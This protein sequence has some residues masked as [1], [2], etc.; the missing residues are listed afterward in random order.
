VLARATARRAARSGAL[1]GAVF[2]LTVVS[3]AL[4]YS[5]TF[6]TAASRAKLAASLGTNAG[7][8]ALLGTARRIDTVAGFTA[9][10]CLG[11]LTLIGA[12]WGLLTA[13]RLLRGEE[14][15]GRWEL[16]LS[17]QTTRRGAASQAVAGL[18]AGLLALW[19]VTAGLTVAAGST[20]EAGFSITASLFL[21]TALVMGAAVFLAVGAVVSQLAGTR[22]QANGIAAGVLGAS[23]LLRMVADSSSQPRGLGGVPRNQIL[24]WLRWAS[25]LGWA[26]ELHPLTGSRPAALIPIGVLVAVLVAVAVRLAEGRDLGASALPS[27]ESPPTRLRLLGGTTGLTVRLARP[28]AVAWVAALG[29]C[30]LV[31]GLVAQSAASAVSG[32]TTIER[33]MGRLGGRQAGAASYLGLTFLVAASLIAFAAAG[34]IAAARNEEAGGCLD[35]LLARPVSRARWLAGRMGV[36][37]GIVTAA[38]VV[39]GL[40]AWAGAAS[41]HTGV[42]L[43]ALAQAGLNVVPPAL[44]VL[45]TGAAA[46]GFWPRR[47]AAVTYG[48]VAWSLLVQLIAAGVT[49]NRWLLDTSLFHHITPAPAADPNWAAAAGLAGLGLIGAVAGVVAFGRRDLVS[50]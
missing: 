33:L 6:P 30:G 24:Y 28:V 8:A 21:A 42:G 44:F 36:G 19:A 39:A 22:R 35:N 4:G 11:L 20:A 41:Q 2:G 1:W 27:R 29:A 37:A 50:A 48:L 40:G 26:E 9:W 15:A 49:T 5:A 7:V 13:T 32:S 34:Q 12:I 3:T 46:V 25:P 31:F 17:G 14:E 38:G 45:G 47:A 23:F 10:R 43:G 16:F 18:G